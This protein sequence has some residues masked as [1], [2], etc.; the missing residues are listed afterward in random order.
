ML[1]VFE[2]A[3]RLKVHRMTVYR[4][5]HAQKIDAFKVG[6]SYR[7]SEEAFQAYLKEVRTRGGSS[8]RA[9]SAKA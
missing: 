6:G 2:V 9:G 5:I 8:G 4:L 7:I 1:D 3:E